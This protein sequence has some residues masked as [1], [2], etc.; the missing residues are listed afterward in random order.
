MSRKKPE[1][2]APVLSLDPVF[3][4]QVWRGH[5]SAFG[6]GGG[7]RFRASAARLVCTGGG[8]SQKEPEGGN[9]E[10]KSLNLRL[11]RNL[12]RGDLIQLPTHVRDFSGSSRKS[13]TRP[14]S[15]DRE[16][17]ISQRSVLYCWTGLT[18]SIHLTVVPRPAPPKTSR[19]LR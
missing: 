19:T 15:S 17:P 16:L 4:A 3:I 11:G 5:P 8:P 7:D 14:C 2:T 6:P 10:L 9:Q 12:S 1:K 18:P 13:A